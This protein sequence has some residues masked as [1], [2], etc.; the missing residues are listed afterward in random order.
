MKFRKYY[1]NSAVITA[2]GVYEYR[3]VDKDE[4]REWASGESPIS[5]VGY[6]QTAVALG[7]ILRQTVEVC[8]KNIKME[9]GDEALVFRLV[10]PP[11]TGRIDPRDKG[12]LD[13]L[14]MRGCYEIGILKKVK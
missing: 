8:R 5:T 1:L 10:F 7:E 9:T 12:A 11:G 3:L 14:V 13:D 2:E 6:E 4:A